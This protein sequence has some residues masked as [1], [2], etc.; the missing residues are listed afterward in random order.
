MDIPHVACIIAFL[1]A[2]IIVFFSCDG[3]AWPFTRIIV[4]FVHS[5]ILFDDWE[6]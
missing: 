5:F 3:K 6:C 1:G 4:G 2:N